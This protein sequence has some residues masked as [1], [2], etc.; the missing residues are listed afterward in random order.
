MHAPRCPN[1]IRLERFPVR[2]RG[3]LLAEDIYFNH[4]DVS[5]LVGPLHSHSVHVDGLWVESGSGRIKYM[6]YQDL[7]LYA[8]GSSGDPINR[9]I[10]AVDQ[11]LSSKICCDNLSEM[12]DDSYD[13]VSEPWLPTDESQSDVNHYMSMA[14]QYKI[15]LLLQKL[16]TKHNQMLVMERDL[17]IMSLRM[18]VELGKKN[19]M[20][21]AL[22]EQLRYTVQSREPA[23]EW[24]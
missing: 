20:I 13:V 4:M 8:S 22:Q 18:A 6:T 3:S 23:S 5:R 12:T 17:T 14:Y 9:F 15:D 7:K 1:I 19:E 16:E 21:Q 2:V 24:I 10:A 11:S